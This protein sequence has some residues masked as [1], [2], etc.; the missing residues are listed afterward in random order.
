[1]TSLPKAVPILD[2]DVSM[3]YD[4]FVDKYEC[5]DEDVFSIEPMEE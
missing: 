4:D 2:E 5:V 1:M 3:D